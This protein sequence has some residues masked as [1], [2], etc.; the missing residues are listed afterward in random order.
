MR[1]N[2]SV[3]QTKRFTT[4]FSPLIMLD[5]LPNGEQYVVRLSFHYLTVSFDEHGKPQHW[6]ALAESAAT[7]S[8]LTPI[9]TVINQ[10]IIMPTVI[11]RSG[12]ASVTMGTDENISLLQ[13]V[14]KM[15]LNQKPLNT[16]SEQF[17][18]IKPSISFRIKHTCD[19]QTIIFGK[20]KNKG[21]Q[22]GKSEQ[23]YVAI[24]A[25]DVNPF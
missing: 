14:S 17:T 2:G 15:F 9:S 20:Q 10:F 25:M 6:R 13:Y 4:E 19:L 22:I 21:G 24:V 7:L 11:F 1:F 12:N 16:L 5:D 18:D 8:C 3:A 23:S